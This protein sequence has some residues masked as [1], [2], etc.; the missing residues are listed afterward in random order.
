MSLTAQ[1]VLV[2]GVSGFVGSNVAVQ[3]L[4]EGYAVR[5]TARGSKVAAFKETPVGQNPNF[6]IVEVEDIA[7]SDLGGILTG[8]KC[9]IHTASPLAGKATPAESFKACS[10]VRGTLNVLE[11]AEKAGITKVVLTS[12]WATTMDP[13]LDKM[14]QGV[15]LSRDEWGTATEEDLLT[16]SHNPLWNYLATKILAE[17]AAWKFAETHPSLDLTTIN[18]P[19]IYGPL[20]PD[21]PTP[22]KTRLGANV[23]MYAL[24]AGA[25]GRALPPQLAPFYCDVRDVARAHVRSLTAGRSKS[26]EKK[27]FLICGGAFTLKAAVEYLAAARPELAARLPSTEAATPLPGPLSTADVSPAKDVLGMDEYIPCEKSVSDAIDC[28]LVAEKEWN[29]NNSL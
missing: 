10:A 1:I 2:T 16:G 9:I 6:E 4:A 26:G 18:P 12:S 28:F 24:I 14:Y 21:F 8:V 20:H 13:S 3:L 15:T 25:P 5:G 7:T 19:F 11:Q 22:E 23:M 29:R 17:S 27:R